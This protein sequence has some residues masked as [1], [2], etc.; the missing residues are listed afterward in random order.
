[1][2]ATRHIRLSLVRICVLW[3]RPVWGLLDGDPVFN[4]IWVVPGPSAAP[5]LP[6]LCHCPRRHALWPVTIPVIAARWLSG[7]P[8]CSPGQL[9][10]SGLR[11]P[12]LRGGSRP[13]P[14]CQTRRC[15]LLP[16]S[17]NARGPVCGGELP[18]SWSVSRRCRSSSVA[19]WL[20]DPPSHDLDRRITDAWGCLC[21]QSPFFVGG[22]RCA[23]NHIAAALGSRRRVATTCSCSG[24]FKVSAWGLSS[25]WVQTFPDHLGR[26]RSFKH[27]SRSFLGR[28]WSVAPAGLQWLFIVFSSG[29]SLSF[30][31][32]CSQP[33][34]VV[35]CS[36]KLGL[37]A[38]W[39]KSCM[40]LV[41]V[42][43]GCVLL[44]SLPYWGGGGGC[45]GC[46]TQLVS[47]SEDLDC[48]FTNG[49]MMMVSASRSPWRHR[50][51]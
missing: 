33:G 50:L 2:A 40:A 42:D 34:S 26:C 31:Q 15:L 29:Y 20:P 22:P 19:L 44:R 11:F 49:R 9:G 36:A 32:S 35:G 21:H 23:T 51:A 27:L 5:S 48:F 37:M 1:M 25:V 24:G 39:R 28:L 14:W 13:R 18:R 6:P 10:V 4:R 41:C 46:R 7:G 12:Q 30:Q 43:N 16:V 38:L 47:P 17:P 8:R 3:V 45:R